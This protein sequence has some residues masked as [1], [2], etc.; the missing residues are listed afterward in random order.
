MKTIR[1]LQDNNGLLWKEGETVKL[2]LNGVRKGVHIAKIK[3]IGVN[4]M[5]IEIDGKD[6]QLLDL[7]TVVKI[8]AL[9]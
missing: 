3:V 1:I 4:M 7:Q 6:E 2:T 9:A 8:E 5:T